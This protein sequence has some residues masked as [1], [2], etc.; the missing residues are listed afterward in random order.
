MRTLIFRTRSDSSN[1]W[2]YWRFAAMLIGLLIVSVGIWS[3]TGKV[4]PAT[5]ERFGYL[6]IFVISFLANASV[7]LPLA[8]TMALVV[9]G[10]WWFNAVP[11]VV[12]AA[13]GSALGELVSY[14]L[15]AG[16]RRTLPNSKVVALVERWMQHRGTGAL[17]LFVLAAVP[18]P[19]VDVAGILAGASRYPWW[20]FL[21]VVWLG[22][23]VRFALLAAGVSFWMK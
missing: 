20:A 8:P 7:F 10:T 6:G 12:V 11:V 19:A 2:E 1:R 22:R 4:E 13:A 5:V 3:F 9:A 16:G 21:A 14:A 17:T 15:G 23:L 18:N